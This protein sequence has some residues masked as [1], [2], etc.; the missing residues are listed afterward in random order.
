LHTNFKLSDKPQIKYS[1]REKLVFDAIASEQSNR[2]STRDIG[3]KV[4]REDEVFH[5]KASII[6]ALAS[7]KRKVEYNKEPFKIEISGHAGPRPM[8]VW[9]EERD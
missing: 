5:V 1:H 7:L 4:F 3:E 9:L 6:S 2:L 8:E